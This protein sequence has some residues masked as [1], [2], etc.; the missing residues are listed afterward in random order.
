MCCE[1]VDGVRFRGESAAGGDAA[2][3]EGGDAG[4]GAA[5]CVCE[6][7]TGGAWVDAARCDCAR[8]L[9]GRAAGVVFEDDSVGW[10][11]A[12]AHEVVVDLYGA[13]CWVDGGIDELK[14]AAYGE[15]L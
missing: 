6:R 14:G 12:G 3:G 2:G 9:R 13:A 15:V 8:V 4:R 11:C 5:I 10:G 1:R 7:W